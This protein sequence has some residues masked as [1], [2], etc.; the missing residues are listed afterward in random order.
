MSGLYSHAESAG[1][2]NGIVR[3]G[4]ANAIGVAFDTKEIMLEAFRHADPWRAA[5]VSIHAS[6]R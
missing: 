5:T 1:H 3:H 4:D 6:A 2:G